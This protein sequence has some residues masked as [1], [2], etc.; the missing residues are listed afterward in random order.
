MLKSFL[1]NSLIP[2]LMFFFHSVCC[3][4]QSNISLTEDSRVKQMLDSRKELNFKKNRLIKAW[5]IQLFVTRDKYVVIEKQEE[6]IDKFKDVNIDWSYEQPFY[7]LE[8]GAYYTKLDAT[9]ALEKF[10][11]LYPEAF[12]IKKSNAKASD[13]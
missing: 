8:S 13:F 5:S 10:K 1:L 3:N 9:M 6:I 12:V 2:L 4:A 7:R 11:K